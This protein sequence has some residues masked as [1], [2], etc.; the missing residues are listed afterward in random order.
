[1]DW[2]RDQESRGILETSR[3][4]DL[5]G[6]PTTAPWSN[7]VIR[8][9]YQR[10]LV[11]TG[12]QLKIRNPALTG[13]L[14]LEFGAFF[15]QPFHADRLASLYTR[16]FD[17]LGDATST[18]NTQVRRELV[19][20]M[21]EGRG[22]NEIARRI[23]AKVDSIGIVRARRIARTEI[24]HAHNVGALAGMEQAE[25]ILGTPVLAKWITAL[26]E[27][28]RPAHA[29]RHAKIYKR[30]EALPLLGEPNCR[31]NL[32]PYIEKPKRKVRRRRR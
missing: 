18:M 28:V 7:T 2:L 10:G 25:A 4:R 23:N 3:Q 24:V 32:I 22:P 27:R 12:P 26:D 31:C 17:F 5:F 15:A 30:E 11:K 9:A 29:A 13:V 14:D 16:V 19:L 6:L 20:G 1:M 21:A 8:T